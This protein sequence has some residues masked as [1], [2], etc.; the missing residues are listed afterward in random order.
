[1]NKRFGRIVGNFLT[2]LINWCTRRLDKELLHIAQ[3]F[4]A[5]LAE[6]AGRRANESNPTLRRALVQLGR[7]LDKIE[8]RDF[9]D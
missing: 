7:E 2:R 4:I 3:D 8:E 1:M 9:S 5:N 6:E